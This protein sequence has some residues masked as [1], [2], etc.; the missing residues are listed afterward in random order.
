MKLGVKLSPQMVEWSALEDAWAAAGQTEAFESVWTFD[1][2]YPL[3]GEGSCFEGWTTLA[4]LAHHARG[5]RIGH[6]VLA[7][8]YR[9]PGLLA[10]MATVM[11]HASD[12]RF[13]LGLSAGWH[14]DEARAFALPM[15]PIGERM[16]IL[17]STLLVTRSLLRPS[18]GPNGVVPPGDLDF[19][20]C[21]LE[22]A[23][24]DPAPL[25]DGPRIVVGTE[26]ERV[27]LRLVARWADGW[28]HSAAREADPDRFAKRLAVLHRH[29]EEAGR[30]PATIEVSVQLPVGLE[31][32][33]RERTVRLGEAYRAAGCHL[34]VLM[35]D[36]SRG[37]HG[38]VEAAG[39]VEALAG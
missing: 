28:N 17:E 5:K 31:G 11:D 16:R 7:A 29:C 13:V 27:G 20:P 18:S 34:L 14:E 37:Q 15:P 23:R 36:P 10:K 26:G 12:G 3:R 22:A 4:V 24:N 25:G 8:T 32:A 19:P 38:V 33:G 2:L 21:R 39:I 1:H 35:A 6:L 9:S 30:D